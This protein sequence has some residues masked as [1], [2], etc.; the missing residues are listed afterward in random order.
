MA[1]FE[2]LNHLRGHYYLFSCPNSVVTVGFTSSKLMIDFHVL[3]DF[4]CGFRKAPG[5]LQML[6]KIGSVNE[7]L[8]HKLI[9]DVDPGPQYIKEIA[10]KIQNYLDVKERFK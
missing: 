5:T 8:I 2:A 6:N 7:E 9:E 3:V 4:S 10:D 1:F